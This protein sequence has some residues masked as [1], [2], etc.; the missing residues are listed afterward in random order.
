MF[1]PL[2]SEAAPTLNDVHEDELPEG[3]PVDH[4]ASYLPGP[5]LVPAY[6]VVKY[7]AQYRAVVDVLLAAQDTSLTG[8][9]YDDVRTGVAVYL[10]GRVPADAVENMVA[11]DRFNL[12]AR[13][14]QLVR[15]G[16]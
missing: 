13:L 16:S 15:W 14:E 11:E 1:A 3:G 12:E 10:A 4:W 8:L 5:D 9:S 6:L 7:A 2:L